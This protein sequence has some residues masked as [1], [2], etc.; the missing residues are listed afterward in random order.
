MIDG[1]VTLGPGA[2]PELLRALRNPGTYAVG[3]RVET[4]QRQ[5]CLFSRIAEAKSAA[6]NRCRHD[7]TQAGHRVYLTGA[8]YAMRRKLIDEFELP[9]QTVNDDAHLSV[10]LHRRGYRFEFCPS[11]LCFVGY[12]RNLVDLI[13]QNLRTRIGRR[14]FPE[15][16]EHL[17]TEPLT[18]SYLLR[19]ARQRGDLRMAVMLYLGLDVALRPVAAVAARTSWG[20]S[21]HRWTP[22]ASTKSRPDVA[23]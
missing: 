14:Q 10:L 23:T 11:A 7:Q 9:P 2:V 13:R 8:L 16:P 17:A 3:A 5:D 22:V 6:L 4:I 19:V 1:D 20:R 12:P 18:R 15:F 21:F